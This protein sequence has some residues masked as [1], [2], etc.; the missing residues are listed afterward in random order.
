MAGEMWSEKYRKISFNQIIGNEGARKAFYEWIKNWKEGDKAVL[1]VGQAGTGKNTT[2]YAAARELG[3]HVVELNASDTRT[4]EKLIKKLGF[5]LY[6]VGLFDEK[7]LVLFDEVDGIYGRDDYGGTEYI[8]ELLE[9]PP[10]PIVL[11]A[12]DENNENVIK[13]EKKTIKISFQK[14]PL[15]MII[16]YLK[17]IVELEGKKVD[18]KLLNEIAKKSDGDVRAAINL[19]Q[20]MVD[21]P[22]TIERMDLLKDAIISKQDALMALFNE[23]NPETAYEK[24][25]KIDFNSRDKLYLL[26]YSILASGLDK[27]KRKAAL[28]VISE[29]DIFETRIEST[30]EWR[31]LKWF[32]RIIVNKFYNQSFRQGIKYYEEEP[33]WEL[34]IKYWTELRLFKSIKERVNQRYHTSNSDFVLYYIPCLVNLARKDKEKTF[35]YLQYL[36]FND[37]FISL[38][39]KRVKT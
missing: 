8:N 2:I 28:R 18:L 21:A 24:F 4:K 17:H 23:E 36:G 9:K 35:R 11:T 32:D 34:K 10:V 25:S 20:S 5:S 22:K 3:Y 16:M 38:I 30:Q 13:L 19:L 26:F 37:N 39:D 12:N 1:L 29:I 7:R 6:T 27:S 31:M 33:L 14:V 15:K